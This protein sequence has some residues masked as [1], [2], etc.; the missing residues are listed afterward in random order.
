[1]LLD[2]FLDIFSF[3]AFTAA[4]EPF[5]GLFRGPSKRMFVS[6]VDATKRQ[7][8]RTLKGA[9]VDAWGF[10]EYVDEEYSEAGEAWIAFKVAEKHVGKARRSLEDAGIQPSGG[11]T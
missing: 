10:N 3:D 11:I 6:S 8:K 9:G 4:F 5:V 7:V 1:M 2:G